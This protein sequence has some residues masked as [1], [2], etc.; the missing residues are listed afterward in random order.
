[1]LINIVLAIH[2]GATLAMLGLIWFVQIVHYPL[3][4][5]VDSASFTTYERLHTRQT[6]WVVGPLMLLELVAAVL[7]TAVIDAQDTYYLA[8]IG[9]ALL[10]VIWLSTMLLQVP[11]HRGLERAFDPGTIRR[12]VATNW[13]RTIAWT[14]RSVVALI[15]VFQA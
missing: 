5:Q 3:M 6:S 13:I 2:A 7:L 4:L 11:C 12:L 14:G 1:M 15:L 8:W 10:I 9:F